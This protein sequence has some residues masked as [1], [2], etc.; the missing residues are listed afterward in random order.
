MHD[1]KK[2]I[3]M[4]IRLT[5]QLPIKEG[6]AAEFEAAAGAALARVR[7]EDKGCEM[8]DLFKSCDDD[9]RFVLVESWASEADLEAHKTSDA[10]GGVGKAFGEFLAGRPVLHQYED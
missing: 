8:Y 9:S 3:E 4:P 1:G 6:K 10:M 7:A 2:E 5:V